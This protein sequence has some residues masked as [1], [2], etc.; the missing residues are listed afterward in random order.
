[1]LV[2]FAAGVGRSLVGGA[3]WV[4]HNALLRRMD[5]RGFDPHDYRPWQPCAIGVRRISQNERLQDAL[6]DISES[7]EDF[8]V[9]E[10]LTGRYS[11]LWD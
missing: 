2:C 9:A 4:T 1:M 7:E 3:L 8:Y 5:G 6:H 10:S 11:V